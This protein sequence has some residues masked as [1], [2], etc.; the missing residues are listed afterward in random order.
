MSQTTRIRINLEERDI[1]WKNTRAH[2]PR[3]RRTFPR[4][5]S[6]INLDR[7]SF[8]AFGKIDTFLRKRKCLYTRL[9]S[10]E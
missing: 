4:L 9:C 5:S 3:N 8:K 2:F 1:A 7:T 6:A 10:A